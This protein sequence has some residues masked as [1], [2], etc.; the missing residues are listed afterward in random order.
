VI[1]HD[2]PDELAQLSD[3]LDRVEGA[4][5]RLDAGTYGTCEHC[6]GTI[7]APALER[8]PTTTVCDGCA[9]TRIDG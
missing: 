9:Q 5:S 2:G 1:V 3:A 4:L 7:D 8:D 6:N